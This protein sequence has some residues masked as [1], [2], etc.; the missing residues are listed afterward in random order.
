MIRIAALLA[1]AVAGLLPSC[2]DKSTA[3]A[4]PP[5]EVDGDAVAQFCNMSLT[6]HSGPKGQIFVKDDPTPFWFASVHDLFAFVMLGDT[7]KAITALYVNDM[8]KAKNWDQPEPGTWIDARRAF[9]VIGSS[10]RGGMGE[11]EA[12]PFSNEDAAQRFIAQHGGRLVR[13]DQMPRDYVLASDTSSPS[14]PP[15]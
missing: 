11:P 2:E 8:A 13:F 6:E 14:E 1:L 4:P 9:Y 3:A 12:V 15:Q 7:P 10:K 5:H